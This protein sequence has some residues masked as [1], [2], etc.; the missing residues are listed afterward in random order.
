MAITFGDPLSSNAVIVSLLKREYV[1]H[2]VESWWS[3]GGGGGGDG[4]GKSKGKGKVFCGG[5]G[6]GDSCS[7]VGS[8]GGSGGSGVFLVVVVAGA[9]CMRWWR[10]DGDSGDG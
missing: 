4:N 7:G 3:D 10:S 5:G 1:V 9:E 6:R 2:G 8:H